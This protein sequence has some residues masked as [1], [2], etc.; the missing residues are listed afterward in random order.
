METESY[1]SNGVGFVFCPLGAILHR[2]DKWV[3]DPP[4]GSAS[5]RLCPLSM[6]VHGLRI[7]I[8]RG[9]DIDGLQAGRA[10]F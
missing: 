6:N 7:E 1:V 4:V 3:I 9:V 10:P 2:R 8:S 5:R